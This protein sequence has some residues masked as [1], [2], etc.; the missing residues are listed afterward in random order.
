MPWCDA[1]DRLVEDE[2]VVDG[3]C[4]RCENPVGPGERPPIPM[5]M[6]L[7]IAATVIYLI[8]RSVQLVM[9]LSH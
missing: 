9:W 4:P 3:R 6:K 2:D 1:C 5:R 8:W 7:L